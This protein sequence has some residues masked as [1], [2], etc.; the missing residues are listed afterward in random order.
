M[1]ISKTPFRMSFAGGGSDLKTY[2]QHGY[3]SVVSTTINKYIYITVNKR[4]TDKIRVGYSKIEEVKNIEDIE[5]NLVR[6]ALKLLGITNGGIDIVYMSDLLPAHEGSGLGGSSSLIVGTLNALHAYKGEN[7]SA[8]TLAREACKI[9]IE[10]LGH[11]IGKQDQYAA[12]YGGFNHIKF[13]ADESVF[14]NPVIF[15][16]EVIEE[17]NN[18]LLLFYTGINTRSDTILTEQ[19]K[20]TKDNLNIL[21]KMVELSEELLD[22]LK[23]GNI[24]CFGEI[25]HKGWIYKQ[26]LASN[27]T[28][29]IINSYYQKAREAGAIGG[30]ILGSGGGGFLLF[31]TEGKNQDN[32]RKDLSDLK[33]LSF[34]FEPEGSK[35]IYIND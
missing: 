9:E 26:K 24:A 19:R 29:P 11:P 21:D 10:I 2:Y 4:F 33:E 14:I 31:Y 28:N 3:G 22:E 35:I 7:V 15:K 16:K 23:Y 8:E 13:N 32:V 34:K 1:I 27:I 5:H 25:L 12:A 30:K 20:K 18:R 17:L 6:E